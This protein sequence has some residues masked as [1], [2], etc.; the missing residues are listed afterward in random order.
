MTLEEA[1]A[2]LEKNGIQV[3]PDGGLE[4][5]GHYIAF[6]TGWDHAVLDDSFDLVELEAIVVWMKAHQKKT[7]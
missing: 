3:N 1:K 4:G 5:G 2:I 6:T 7:T